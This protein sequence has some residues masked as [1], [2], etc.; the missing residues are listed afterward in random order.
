MD[1]RCRYSRLVRDEVLAEWSF[2][3]GP[4]L[5]LHCHVSGA[6]FWLASAY[7]R[8]SIFAREMPLVLDSIAFAERDL[9][10]CTSLQDTAVF[11]HFEASEVCAVA[12]SYPLCSFSTG[13][14]LP[15]GDWQ[16]C[17]CVTVHADV[18]FIMI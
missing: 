6:A 11:V 16:A 4:A 1:R 10:S 2:S 7:A 15:F 14:H 3:G 12:P 18:G 17:H 13:S 5:H 9:F 8:N